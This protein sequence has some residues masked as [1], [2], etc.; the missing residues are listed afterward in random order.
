MPNRIFRGMS[1]HY[2]HTLREGDRLNVFLDRAEG[3]HLQEDLTKPMVFVSAGTG[4]APMRAFL[5]E[6]LANKREDT[7]LGPAVLFNGIRNSRLDYIYR[8]EIE[9]FVEEGVLDHLHVAMSREVP[10]TRDYGQDR[11]VAQGRLVGEYMRD[12]G[13]VDV[14]GSQAMRNDVRAAMVTVLVEH[15]GMAAEDA[16]GYMVALETVDGR[17]RPDVWG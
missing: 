1:S 3:F 15:G 17:Y 6:R 12:G 2:V 5:W 8:E 13:S 16:E 9:M 11:I 7:A 4:Y 10:G 14:C